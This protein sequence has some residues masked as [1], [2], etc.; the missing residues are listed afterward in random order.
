M[1]EQFSLLVNNRQS[2]RDFNDKPIDKETLDKIV[3]LGLLAPSACNSQPWKLYVVTEENA[4]KKVAHSLQDMMMNKFTNKAQAFIVLAEREATLKLGASLK[5]DRNHF[6]K[7]DIGQIC[8]YLTLGAESLGVSSCI[9]GWINE[10]ELKQ[11]ISMPEDQSCKIVIALGY[12]DID[13]RKKSRK[14]F[15]TLVELI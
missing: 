12:S 3:S 1:F 11:A 8:A 14:D 2:C 7:Y 4:R 5:F 13:K 15:E 10:K 6:V 9:I